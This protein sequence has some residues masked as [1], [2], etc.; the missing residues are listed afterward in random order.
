MTVFAMMYEH[1]D[2][3]VMLFRLINAPPY[4]MKTMKKMFYNL[5]QFVVV[6]I[7]DM[8]IFS[9]TKEEHEQNFGMVLQTLCD[10]MFYAKLKRCEFCLLRVG[11]LGHVINEGTSVDLNKAST[12]MEWQR[13]SNV[14]EVR[15]FLG[16]ARYYRRFVKIFSIIANTLSK[17]T[18]NNVKVQ[19]DE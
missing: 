14:K 19:T 12:V 2:F 5:G 8:L 7:D 10:S 15:S 4:F 11:F 17:L 9:N 3:R 16:M 18:H 1:C 13:S 6:F